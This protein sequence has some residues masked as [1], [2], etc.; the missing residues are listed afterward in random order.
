MDD[1]VWARFGERLRMARKSAGLSL[2][3]AGEKL[4]VS[5]TAVLNWEQGKVPFN[6]ARL[7]KLAKVY[8]VR[9]EFFF[10]RTSII[11]ELVRVCRIPR[12][13]NLD[14]PNEGKEERC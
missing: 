3:A 2:R 9:V 10:R 4:D 5:H 14:R 6:S 11:L 1:N 8:G 7:R 13:G 12:Q